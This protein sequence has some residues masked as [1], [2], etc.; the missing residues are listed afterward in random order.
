MNHHTPNLEILRCVNL[1]YR[2]FIV[3][4]TQFDIALVFMGQIQILHREAFTTPPSHDNG[5][6]M[7]LNSPVD[8]YSVTVEDASVY[9]GIPLDIAVERS[10]W[11]FDVS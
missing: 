4:R 1:K 6:V 7:W 2:V 8:D 5:A 3:R 9:H 10:F 11:M